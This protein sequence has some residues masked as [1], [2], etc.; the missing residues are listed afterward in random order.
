MLVKI[1]T[2]TE[3]RSEPLTTRILITTV[4]VLQICTESLR[5]V[6]GYK[7]DIFPSYAF[8]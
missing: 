6:V 2:K 5:Y 3:E 8:R 1:N 4:F 7:I